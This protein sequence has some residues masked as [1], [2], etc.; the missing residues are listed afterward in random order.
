M[1]TMSQF[2]VDVGSKKPAVEKDVGTRNQSALEA[3]FPK[4][5]MF[6]DVPVVSNE[7]LKAAFNA[8]IMGTDVCGEIAVNDDLVY[9]AGVGLGFAKYDPNCPDAPDVASNT[10]TK[11]GI[12]FGKGSG[13]PESP[14]VPPLTSPGPGVVDVSGQPGFLASGESTD[15]FQ[16]GEGGLEWGSGYGSD[17]NPSVTSPLVT[18]KKLGSF[19][20]GESFVDSRTK[21]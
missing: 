19:L 13:A 17:A 16:K 18:D 12:T 1:P 7:N 9:G 10:T 5:P 14:Y 11:D 3:C 8:L 4:S 6:G 15:R 21:G 20:H 2:I